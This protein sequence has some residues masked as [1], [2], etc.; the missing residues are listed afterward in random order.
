MRSEHH[1]RRT[2][3][4][5]KKM[6]L[7]HMRIRNVALY[8]NKQ[9]R[10]DICKKKNVCYNS[11][12]PRVKH[13]HPRTAGVGVLRGGEDEVFLDGHVT[14]QWQNEQSDAEHHQTQNT[15][16]PNHL[17]DSHTENEHDERELHRFRCYNRRRWWWWWWRSGIRGVSHQH[18]P[19]PCRISVLAVNIPA[20]IP[21][22]I[23]SHA[24]NSRRYLKETRSYSEKSKK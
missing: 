1:D 8:R 16:D 6:W 15:D 17:S 12:K 14:D 5:S 7:K 4:L 20:H 13:V 11:P 24:L 3:G 18:R 21:S 10:Y 23:P 19:L 2:R 22:H 9:P